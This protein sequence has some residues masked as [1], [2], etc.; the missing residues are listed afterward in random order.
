MKIKKNVASGK[1]HF[2]ISDF[3]SA[4]IKQPLVCPSSLAFKK[5]VFYSV[6]GFNENIEVGEDTDFLIRANLQYK[7][8]YHNKPTCIYTL[9]SENQ[10]TS[11][12]LVY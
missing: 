11:E 4:S 3:F 5:E 8:A 6:G 7:F 9:F 2:L 12:Y 10:I 1:E